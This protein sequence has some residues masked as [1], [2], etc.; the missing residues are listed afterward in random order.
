LDNKIREDGLASELFS[1]GLTDDGT[2]SGK[3]LQ[4]KRDVGVRKLLP[5]HTAVAEF[6]ATAMKE[7]V[8]GEGRVS[9]RNPDYRITVKVSGITK[10]IV[11]SILELDVDSLQVEAKPAGSLPLEPSARLE[12]LTT[13]RN[14]GLIDDEEW[15]AYADVIEF[16]KSRR[17][18]TA[19]T[20]QIDSMIDD[21]VYEGK[22]RMPREIFV[23]L[24]GERMIREGTLALARAEEDYRDDIENGSEERQEEL[25]GRLAKLE[26]WVTWIAKKLNESRDEAKAEQAPLETPGLPPPEPGI[27]G[28]PGT[29]GMGQPEPLVPPQGNVLPLR[30][31]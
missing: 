10:N 12:V 7:R 4:L 17:R 5:Q 24:A 16:E 27:P 18:K 19:I 29:N 9:E 11:P 6:G 20:D 31:V 2:T 21:I 30:G 25:R 15:H 28:P 22:L 14:D 3:H 8:R 1:S 23:K 26:R 13:L